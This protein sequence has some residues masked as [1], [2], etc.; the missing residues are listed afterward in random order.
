MFDTFPDLFARMGVFNRWSFR[1]GDEVPRR[2]NSVQRKLFNAMFFVETAE[3]YPRSLAG[4]PVDGVREM[5]AMDAYTDAAMAELHD[6]LDMLASALSARHSV[7]NRQGRPY[8]FAQLFDP[9]GHLDSAFATVVGATPASALEQ[10][11]VNARDLIDE[12]NGAKHAG[13]AD[14]FLFPADY[15]DFLK[16]LSEAVQPEVATGKDVRDWLDTLR[17]RTDDIGQ[18]ICA[19]VPMLFT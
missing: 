9:S 5:R 15:P 17:A 8:S 10:L 3:H 6:A 12:N 7:T 18:R 1:R 13:M 14:V 19:M 11:M 2:I 16:E 4:R